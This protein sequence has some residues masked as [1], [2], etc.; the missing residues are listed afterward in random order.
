MFDLAVITSFFVFKAYEAEHPG[1]PP[2]VKREDF[3]SIIGQA[4]DW[5]DHLERT[6]K[7]DPRP[8]QSPCC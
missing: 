5:I 4:N 1:K 8:E 6:G 7:P 3:E 2:R